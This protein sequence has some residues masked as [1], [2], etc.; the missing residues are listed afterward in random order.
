MKCWQIKWRTEIV[1]QQQRFFTVRFLKCYLFEVFIKWLYLSIMRK[2]I[3]LIC[4]HI[5]LDY[6]YLISIFSAQILLFL[7]QKCGDKDGENHINDSFLSFQ[8]FCDYWIELKQMK[9]NTTLI[10]LLSA[11]TSFQTFLPSGII[12]FLLPADHWNIVCGFFP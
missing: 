6:L 8:L 7:I 5:L 12:S 9:M 10:D 2:L 3:A 1:K 11:N 4:Y